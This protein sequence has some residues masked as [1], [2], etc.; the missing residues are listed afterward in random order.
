VSARETQKRKETRKA[1]HLV[2]CHIKI[3]LGGTRWARL[4]TTI[5]A[6]C[7]ARKDKA[8]ELLTR[9]GLETATVKGS[10]L[11]QGWVAH[12]QS[13]CLHLLLWNHLGLKRDVCEVYRR[14]REQNNMHKQ[15]SGA[16]SLTIPFHTSP[17]HHSSILSLFQTFTLLDMSRESLRMEGIAVGPTLALD[18]LP[19]LGLATSHIGYMKKGGS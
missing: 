6:D 10:I 18:L 19:S 17:F 2:K 11:E 3:H 16:A 5:L 9:L 14:M 1:A 4:N 12:S 15:F 8:H 7:L 13:H